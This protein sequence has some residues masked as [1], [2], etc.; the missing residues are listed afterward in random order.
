VLEDMLAGLGA[1]V[2]PIEA[3]LEP[4]RGAYEHGHDERDSHV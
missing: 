3:P 4:E 2:T 1:D